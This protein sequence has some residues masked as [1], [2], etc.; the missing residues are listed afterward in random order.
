MPHHR[1]V[2]VVDLAFLPGRRD[3]DRVRLGRL[4]PAQAAQ[5][6][7]HAGVLGGKAVVVDE[8]APDRD[9]VAAVRD[10]QFDQV[11]VRLKA[12]AAGAR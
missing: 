9:S 3:D 12:L 2:A 5:E 11:P 7:V 6:A 10:G 8:I 4:R 1:A